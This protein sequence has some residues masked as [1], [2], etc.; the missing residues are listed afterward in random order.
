MIYA[1]IASLDG[2]IEDE[3]GNFDWA[4]PDAEVHA[5]VNDLERPVGTHLFGRR[6][7]ETM[8][9]WEGEGAVEGQP[10]EMRDYAEIWRA[11]DKVVYSTTL[12]APRSERTRI[13]RAFEPEE[14]RRMKA[15][16]DR[17]LTI[18]G[19]ELAAEALRA[20]LVDEIHLFV[21]P[22]LVGGGKPAFP[23]DFRV[24]LELL[25]E[26]RFENGTL[27]LRYRARS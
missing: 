25:E 4:A 17:D 9:F 5:F 3:S 27:Y 21:A 19:P 2:F 10:A 24:D 13:E 14:V 18:G 15:E 6:M 20:G 12:A 16:A 23:G 22:V 26:R 8:A 11:A 1:T 7:Y